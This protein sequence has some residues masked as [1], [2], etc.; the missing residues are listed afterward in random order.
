MCE[1]SQKN[2]FLG[3]KNEKKE[4]SGKEKWIG[5]DLIESIWTMAGPNG[6]HVIL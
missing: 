6:R 4:S 1:N 5:T 2:V 3:K